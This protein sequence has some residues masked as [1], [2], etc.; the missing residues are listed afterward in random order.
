MASESEKDFKIKNNL[1]VAG[2]LRI[3]GNL[4]DSN[5]VQARQKISPDS[6]FVITQVNLVKQE[7]DIKM[8]DLE[9]KIS[10]LVSLIQLINTKV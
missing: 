2:N 5:W 3:A 1:K 7:Y 9:N 8:K 6:D 10:D 4:L